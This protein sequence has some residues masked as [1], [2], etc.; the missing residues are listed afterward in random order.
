[1]RAP[2]TQWTSP[3]VSIQNIKRGMSRSMRSVPICFQDF[4]VEGVLVVVGDEDFVTPL[5][6]ALVAMRR[7]KYNLTHQKVMTSP[8]KVIHFVS[9]FIHVYRS[10][11]GELENLNQIK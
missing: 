11:I 10:K 7:T 6:V 2:R 9:R 8:C 1:M 5:V 3:L 4:F